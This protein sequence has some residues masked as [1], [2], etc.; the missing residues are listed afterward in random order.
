MKMIT[1]QS[2]SSQDRD[3]V[4]TLYWQIHQG[5]NHN[6][7]IKDVPA[8]FKVSVEQNWIRNTPTIVDLRLLNLLFGQGYQFEDSFSGKESGE[9]FVSNFQDVLEIVAHSWKKIKVIA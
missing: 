8:T 9:D 7:Q 1:H 6:D 5:C 3:A 2:H 4:D